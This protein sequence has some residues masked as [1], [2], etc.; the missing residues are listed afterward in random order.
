MALTVTP[1]RGPWFAAP[2]VKK[3]IYQVA[4]DSSYPTGGEPLDL[5]DDFDHVFSVRAG[6]NDTLADNGYIVDSIL[7]TPATVVTSTNVTLTLHWDPADGSAAEVMDEFT[8]TG[9]ASA[10][11]QCTVLVEGD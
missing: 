7:P 8:D 9:N 3:A 11:G 1:V 2:G 10:I 6:G 4:F 5:T